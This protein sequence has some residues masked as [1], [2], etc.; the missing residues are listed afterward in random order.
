LTEELERLYELLYLLPVG[1][2]AFD[3]AGAVEAIN[4]LSVQLL[5]PFVPPSAMQNA[6]ALLAPLVS[7]LAELTARGVSQGIVLARRRGTLTPAGGA[8]RTVEFSVHCTSP[9]QYVAM[10][11]DVTD[12]VR[13]EHEL[14]RERNRIRIIVE[15]VREY[16][17]YTIDRSGHVDSW[18]ASGQRMFGLSTG[19]AIGASLDAL[20]ANDEQLVDALDEAVLAG[21]RRLQGWSS[22]PDGTAFYSDTMISTLVDEAGHPD[23]F[24]VITQDASELRRR[25]DELRHEADTDPLTKLANRRGFDARAAPL[26]TSC[27]SN[28]AAVSVMMLDIDHFKMVNDTYGHDAGDQVLRSLGAALIGRLRTIDLI[29]RFGGEEFAVLL[30]GATLDTAARTAEALRA[31]V[32]D[33]SIEVAPNTVI[34]V[35]ISI[36]VTQLSGD[37]T[38]TLRHA[39]T[40]LYTAKRLGRNRIA[41]S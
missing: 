35:T 2:V 29:A 38:E 7:D 40:A 20:A 30:P 34:H 19:Q 11:S 1:V 9:G 5:N 10:L 25:E 4:P 32:E 6:F 3:Q 24:V 14:R 26:I 37:L 33:L 17:I 16:A 27:A 31:T 13:Q 12:V 39:D 18:N 23:G 21:W 15:M 36:G 41:T 22:G 28:G 8:P